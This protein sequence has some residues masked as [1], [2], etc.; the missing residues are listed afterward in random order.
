MTNQSMRED[1][2]HASVTPP[3]PH[4]EKLKDCTHFEVCEV[5]G[6]GCTNWKSDRCAYYSA[7]GMS[8][9]LLERI[10][11]R[12]ISEANNAKCWKNKTL[13]VGALINEMEVAATEIAK[14]RAQQKGCEQG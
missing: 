10:E 8:A 2:I 6:R 4:I 13:G 14:L 11:K 12:L 3:R 9:E 1:E 5:L 7:L